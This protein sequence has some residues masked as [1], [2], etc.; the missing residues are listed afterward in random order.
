[1]LWYQ[2]MVNTTF[3]KKKKK[4]TINNQKVSRHNHHKNRNYLDICLCGTL[5]SYLIKVF[6]VYVAIMRLVLSNKRKKKKEN[7]LFTFFKKNL[8]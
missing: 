2:N 7:V 4:N 5:F 3:L 8:F 6:R 1:M